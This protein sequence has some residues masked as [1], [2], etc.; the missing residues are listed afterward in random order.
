MNFPL[1]FFIAIFCFIILTN[2]QTV[3]NSS[4]LPTNTAKKATIP[5]FK[6][7]G[8]VGTSSAIGK[9]ATANRQITEIRPLPAPSKRKNVTYGKDIYPIF[10]QNCFI[11]HGETIQAGGLRLDTLEFTL[12][13]TKSNKVIVPGKS[14][15]SLLVTAVAQLDDDSAMPPPNQKPLTSKQIGLIRAW[16]IQG[17]K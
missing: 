14:R 13:G 10:K 9:Q 7:S 12:A 8:H 4:S 1:P 11:C 2:A 3:N 5:G 16:I 6:V 15:K 17:A